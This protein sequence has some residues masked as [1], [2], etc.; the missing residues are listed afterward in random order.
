MEPPELF[1]ARVKI[2]GFA[3]PPAV[4]WI[5]VFMTALEV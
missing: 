3:P 5:E 2:N 4:N 1:T